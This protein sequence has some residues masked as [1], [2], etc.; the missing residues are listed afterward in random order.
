MTLCGALVVG[1]VA[2]SLALLIGA[3]LLIR[4][5]A[6][7][8][9]T[10]PGFSV[11]HVLTGEIQLLEAQY[12]DGRKQIQFFESVRDALLTLPGVKAVGFSSHLPILQRLGNIPAWAAD[13]QPAT[14][15]ERRLAHARIVLPGYF[16]ALRIPLLAGRDFDRTGSG[17]APPQLLINERMAR[18]L[19]PARNPLGQRVMVDA[20][21]PQPIPCE[22]VGVVGDARIDAIGVPAP[23]TM[24][25][26]YYQMPQATMR[27]AIRT[28]QDPE[29][30]VQAVRKLVAALDRDI[31]VEK[32]LSMESLV[33]D[34]LK[35]QRVTAVTLG[36][37]SAVALL[38]ACMGLYGVLAYYVTQRTQEIGIRMSLGADRRKIIKHVLARSG[39][40]VVPGLALGLAGALAAGRFVEGLLYNVTPSDPAT[41]VAVSGC[42]AATMFLAS[43]LPAWRASRTDPVLALRRE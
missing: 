29:S 40:L 21:A 4:S 11:Q 43:V 12:P 25:V 26:S 30:T 3:G 38:L 8:T 36:V 34:S 41:F 16:D 10:N 5:F 39:I 22:V 19:F 37:F 15:A 27:L 20:G 28:D 7:L 42:L 1:Q 18:T 2:V 33:A 6:Q 24:Y 35:P 14:P 32:L 9:D 17:N 13:N 23:M 31:P